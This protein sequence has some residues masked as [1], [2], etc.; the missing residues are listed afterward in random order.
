M[1]TI[2]LFL[3]SMEEVI[4][5]RSQI[6]RIEWAI[7]ALEAQVVQCPVSR[8]VVVQEQKP[9]VNFRGVFPSKCHSIEPAE[10]NNILH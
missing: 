7:K 6:R 5:R 4:V 10:M 2:Q 8:G 1:A 3:Q 9:L